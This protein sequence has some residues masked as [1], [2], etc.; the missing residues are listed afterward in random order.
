MS[1]R[2]KRN[3]LIVCIGAAVYLALL[4]ALISVETKHPDATI[5]TVTKGLWYTVTTLTTVGYGDMYPVT[6]A[7]KTIGVVFQL[8]S[9]GLLV[10]LIGAV[11]TFLRGRFLPKA[12]LRAARNKKWYVFSERNRYSE[13][14]AEKLEESDLKGF[15][16]F[17]DSAASDDED[18]SGFGAPFGLS[19][20]LRMK[21]DH[22]NISLF[23]MGGNMS[24]NE[25]ISEQFDDGKMNIYCLSEHEPEHLPANRVVF[26][27]YRCCARSYWNTYPL[28][29][30]EER[31]AL[32]GEGKYAFALLEQALILN[33]ISERQNVVCSVYGD[34]S[35]FRDLHPY[36][37]T[38][39]NIDH[40]DKERD[41]LMFRDVSWS[42][43]LNTIKEADRLIVCFDDEEKT[44]EVLTA[45]YRYCP[46]RAKTY[47][48]LSV[49]FDNT[50]TFGAENEVFTPEY[51]CRD[52]LGRTAVKLHEMYAASN[53][54]KLP[55]WNDLGTFLRRS[56]LASA[57]HLETK[58]HILLGFDVGNKVTP[59]LCE[60][61]YEKFSGFDDK[62]RS[63]L[64][65]IEHDRWMRFHVVNNWQYAPVRDNEKRLHPL[66]V[67][68]DQLSPEEQAKD[69]YAWE[70]LS[71]A[72]SFSS[73]SDRT[74]KS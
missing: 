2:T 6:V 73:S 14:L 17:A 48:R 18:I 27:P 42:A 66:I 3:I 24:E 23:A 36:L 8:M 12:R 71:L 19:A 44:T 35:L 59:E 11:V 65:K 53:P 50:V 72:S 22:E 74:G 57:D 52:E 33:V 64:R 5:T 4:F 43:D 28:N 9:L 34:F 67:P 49:P 20:I 29:D 10:A 37:D 63:R 31:I 7:G 40:T 70:I 32:I 54:G 60:K 56:N 69:D 38:V 30:P 13:A 15:A 61:A 25:R 62:E 41:S 55:G 68:F 47:A 45:I 26:D 46:V 21:K 51:V 1:R 58:I 16:I 39:I